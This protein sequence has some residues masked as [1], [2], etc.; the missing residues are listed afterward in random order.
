[1]RSKRHQRPPDEDGFHTVPSTHRSASVE[2][3]K[4]PPAEEPIVPS[5]E[6]SVEEVPSIPVGEPRSPKPKRRKAS[7]EEEGEALRR[8]EC[9]EP[10]G[11]K[12]SAPAK[13]KR[14]KKKM[15]N[16]KNKTKKLDPSIPVHPSIRN[17]TESSTDSDSEG[18]FNHAVKITR[19]SRDEELTKLKSF[20]SKQR[21]DMTDAAQMYASRHGESLACDAN[22]GGSHFAM[23][24]PTRHDP[25]LN[26]ECQAIVYCNKGNDNMWSYSGKSEWHHVNC[27]G[28]RHM[29]SARQLLKVPAF[30]HCLASSRKPPPAK[31]ILAAVRNEGY[32]AVCDTIWRAVK[33]FGERNACD[34]NKGLRLLPEWCSVFSSVKSNGYANFLAEGDKLI[35]AAVVFAPGLNICREAGMPISMIDASFS[36]NDDEC[37]YT[38][39]AIVGQ[40]SDNKLTV[41]GWGLASGENTEGYLKF[42]ELLYQWQD[43]NGSIL[44]RFLDNENH[45]QF[46]DRHK[47]ITA[48]QRVMM[49][50]A[51]SRYCTVHIL[52]NLKT[53]CPGKWT[54][55]DVWAIQGAETEE[56]YKTLLSLMKVH[57]P[58]AAAY[59][60]SI[61]PIF[62]CKWPFFGK[63][64]LWGHR[65][66]NFIESFNAW[67]LAI[68]ALHPFA[69]F[70]KLV[71]M[72]MEDLHRRREK[73]IKRLE[74]GHLL[75]KHGQKLYDAELEH[76]SSF[77]VSASFREYAVVKTQ[78]LPPRRYNVYF[79]TLECDCGHPQEHKSPCRH[80][81]CW[82]MSQHNKIWTI[83]E[84]KRHACKKYL[85]DHYVKVLSEQ[86]LC[87]VNTD[88]LVDN[89]VQS[90]KL[91]EARK[92]PGRPKGVSK[93]R[94]EA[95]GTRPPPAEHV[96]TSDDEVDVIA[97]DAFEEYLDDDFYQSSLKYCSIMNESVIEPLTREYASVSFAQS[98]P[99]KRYNVYFYTLEC[100]CG[101]PQEHKSPCRHL[102]CWA[103]S[104]H[105]K[106]WT[107]DEWKRHAC[108]LY[109][110]DNYVK[111]LS[112]QCIHPVNTDKL[113]DN[114]V[115]KIN[116]PE[117]RKNPGRPKTNKKP[118]L[119]TQGT[120]PVPVERILNSDDEASIVAA[121]AFEECLE[122]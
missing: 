58:K 40:D 103:M 91:S 83:D 63:R 20:T 89:F 49:P 84:W 46:S 38:H 24:C 80:L 81:I 19:L 55:N 22:D 77:T 17:G 113:V 117:A 67:I 1:M 16:P 74:K 25:E 18:E 108:K 114:L 3:E 87:P 60:E 94:L 96:I 73:A 28:R 65:T 97:A 121:D 45:T 42:M 106:I 100:D 69:A 54:K 9:D 29:L 31:G 68:R 30:V 90:M 2:H 61:D 10:L 47:S 88:R 82:A 99:P 71:E 44:K 98:L 95:Q 111:V 76:Q 79:Y 5:V 26:S 75:V 6:E 39:M 64:A 50:K 93:P 119:E 112:A 104:Q 51:V 7:A 105:N 101:H 72:V 120:R 78:S 59:L 110:L 118:R 53:Y 116:L 34:K 66:S 48:M 107:I 85:L 33:K 8:M 102:I 12:R 41:I 70:D 92:K 115:Q 21:S 43:E 13:P 11:E 62:W 52:S 37:P 36:K 32:E 4:Q 14:Q 23:P 109:L 122:Q 86:A 57:S 56:E 35:C 15:L 27:P